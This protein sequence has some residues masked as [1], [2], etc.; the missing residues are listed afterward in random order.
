MTILYIAKNDEDAMQA[1]VRENEKGFA[2]ILRD[3]DSDLIV[4][5]AVITADFEIA[6]AK[7]DEFVA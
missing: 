3:L 1:E 5:I 6:K 4:P 2:I 7:A